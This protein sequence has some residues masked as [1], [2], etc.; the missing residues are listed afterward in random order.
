MGI[1]LADF[2]YSY[3]SDSLSEPPLKSLV[4]GNF[5]CL[6]LSKDKNWALV[7]HKPTGEQRWVYGTHLRVKEL[8]V[9][10]YDADPTYLPKSERNAL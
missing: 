7:K 8:S 3:G 1:D 9:A 6:Q 4:T 2:F 5:Q 10:Y